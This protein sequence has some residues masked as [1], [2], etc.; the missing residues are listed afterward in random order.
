VSALGELQRL[1]RAGSGVL[2]QYKV[3]LP[4][5]ATWSWDDLKNLGA[6]VSKASGGKVQGVQSWGFDTGGV[7]IWARQAGASLYDDKGTAAFGTWWNTQLASLTA[8]SGQN[9]KL[10]RLPGEAKAASPGAYYKP[11]MFWSISARSKHPAEAALF[12]NFLANTAEA[13]DI[14]LTDRG[15]PA[16]TKVRTAITPKITAVDK[17]AEGFIKELQAEID[18]P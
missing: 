18:A 3:P 5:D 16:N 9:L 14:L 7:N 2:A 10:L 13:G 11:S 6:Q 17:A 1:G 8:A 15:V 12:V 4:D